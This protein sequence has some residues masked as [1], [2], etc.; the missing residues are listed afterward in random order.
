[1]IGQRIKDLR[2]ERGMSR[3]ALARASGLAQNSIYR[4]ESGQRPTPS[5]ES[6]EK[7]AHGLGVHVGDLFE[8]E[9]VGAGKASAPA[10]GQP[11]HEEEPPRTEAAAATR[12]FGWLTDPN[13]A[14]QVIQ[15]IRGDAIRGYKQWGRIAVLSEEND[16]DLALLLDDLE[17]AL[18]FRWELFWKALGVLQ[19]HVRELGLPSDLAMWD[20]V[21]KREI[22]QT[23]AAIQLLSEFYNTLRRLTK[24]PNAD[25]ESVR[26]VSA[27][28]DVEVPESWTRD[29]AWPE[30]KKEVRK[31]AGVGA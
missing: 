8:E 3:D 12:L 13:D 2:I 24:D 27:E 28:F 22:L 1:M 26:A 16:L 7:I 9:P 29:P 11:L 6:L 19:E 20:P 30:A 14:A 5:S 23:G 17:M 10:S 21:S 15:E 25:A 18:V 4:I 31:L